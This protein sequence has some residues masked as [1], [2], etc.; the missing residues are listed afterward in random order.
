VK[1]RYNA[2][3]QHHSELLETLK[4]YQVV[5]VCPEQLGGLATPRPPAQIFNGSGTDVL[6][7]RARIKTVNDRI[8]VT[9]AFIDG[10]YQT[11]HLCRL[12]HVKAAILQQRSPSCGADFIYNGE[13]VVPGAGVTAALLRQMGI[14][15]FAIN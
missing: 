13:N 8:D 15:L 5:P 1:C 12:F 4:P 3:P 7:G 11:A 14:P 10:A 6:E 2:Q 9:P